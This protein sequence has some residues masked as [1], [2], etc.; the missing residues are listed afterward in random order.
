VKDLLDKQQI[1]SATVG[2]QIDQ[3]STTALRSLGG[4]PMTLL[5]QTVSAI[6][7]MTYIAR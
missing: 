2:E 3:L 4:V 7:P 1:F 5:L 6:K